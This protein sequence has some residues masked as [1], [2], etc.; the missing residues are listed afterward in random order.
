MQLFFLRRAHFYL[1]Q[2]STGDYGAIELRAFNVPRRIGVFIAV[3][4]EQPALLLASGLDQGKA[5]AQL[6]P[7]EHYIVFASGKLLFRRDVPFTLL[8]P[9]IPSPHRSP[10]LL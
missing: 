2:G 1:L 10:A 5:T 4:D 9:L 6:F 7:L 3:L 8:P